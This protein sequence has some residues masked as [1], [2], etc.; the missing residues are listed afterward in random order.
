MAGL[1]FAAA[2]LLALPALALTW[3]V[4][5]HP[6]NSYP[7]ISLAAQLALLKDLGARSYRV[8]ISSVDA[9]DKLAEL[10][11][12]AKA[13][14]ITILPV[15]TPAVDLKT[16]DEATLHA[17]AREMALALGTRFKD[18]IRVW[19]L[20]NELENFAIIQPCERRDDGTIYPCEWG[21]AGGVG[22][23]DYYGPRWAKVSAVLRGLSDGM[24]AA[25][26]TIRKAMGTAGWG[27]TGAF[28]RM[29]ADG[30]QWDIS[31]W[32]M[33]GEDPEWAFKLLAAHGRPIWVTEFNHP[34]GS[35]KSATEQ[36]DGLVRWMTRLRELAVPYRIEVAHLYELLDETY[37]APDFEAYMGL[38]ELEGSTAKGWRI[39][40]PKPAYAAVQREMRDEGLTGC[41]TEDLRKVADAAF[42]KA[43]LGYCL[44]LGRPAGLFE[45][46][47]WVRKLEN[48][49]SEAEM[50][51]GLLASQEFRQKHAVADL[52]DRAYIDL[53]Y[54]RLLGRPADGAGLEGYLAD[55]NAGRATRATIARALVQSD[56]FTARGTIR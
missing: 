41:D 16:M 11:A 30:I 31:V 8:D 38:A 3:G 42:R 7:G 12:E 46:E 18:D 39:G 45:A 15:I 9:G 35:Q 27:H 1:G 21:A 20:G 5:G 29:Q 34:F 47:G 52:D 23:L 17:V 49:A 51:E 10:V 56:E 22:A 53:L 25:D 43:S 28:E 48:G 40:K 2:L 55:L 24:T 14:G 54:Q 36:A 13:R 26:P 44:V 50:T 32:H 4:N 33:Y 19:E 37:W 6:I